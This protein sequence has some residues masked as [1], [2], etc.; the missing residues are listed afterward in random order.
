MASVVRTLKKVLI[1]DDN[2]PIRSEIHQEFN[3]QGFLYSNAENGR[4]AIE[5]VFEIL[6]DLIILDLSMPVMN[7]LDAAPELKKILPDCPIILYT[8][9]ADTL[10]QSSDV[11]AR[12]I[13]CVVAK[14]DSLESLID[15]ANELFSEGDRG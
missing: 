1:V 8:L 13:T 2:P 9:F 6:P 3:R 5:Q 4:Q 15:R 10:V 7:G 11:E 14:D 12:G